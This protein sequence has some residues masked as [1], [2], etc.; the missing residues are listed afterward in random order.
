MTARGQNDRRVSQHGLHSTS[1]D[2]RWN[3]GGDV[4]YERRE[5]G[6]ACYERREF[7]DA[8]VVAN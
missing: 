5:F 4:C 6:D 8:S 3:A 2:R 7:G 1:A